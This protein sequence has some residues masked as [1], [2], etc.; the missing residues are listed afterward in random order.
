[1]VFVLHWVLPWRKARVLLL[2]VACYWFYSRWDAWL[3]LLVAGSS[4][5]DSALGRALDAVRSP[6]GRFLLMLTSVIGNLSL[7]TYFKYMNFFLASLEAALR[8]AGMETSFPVLAILAPIGISFYTFEALSYTVDVYLR[9][10]PAE[11][12]LFYFMLFIL[13]FPHLVAGPIV[14]GRD[15]LPQIRHPKRWN[16]RR[17]QVTLRRAV[18]EGHRPRSIVLE[19]LPI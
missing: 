6:R 10:I 16:W 4:C 17:M 2:L 11:R 9:R 1:V 14:R 19:I 8:Q 12:N 7:L 15:Y 5:V 18:A 3:A 13:F